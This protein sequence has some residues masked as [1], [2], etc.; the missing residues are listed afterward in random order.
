MS[1]IFYCRF[2]D[3][4]WWICSVVFHR[5]WLSLS[6]MY[7]FNITETAFMCP[8]QSKTLVFLDIEQWQTVDANNS[9][10][11]AV[12]RYQLNTGD[13]AARSVMFRQTKCRLSLVVTFCGTVPAHPYVW[14]SS[15]PW[16]HT[17][18]I[19]I[20]AQMSQY[21]K[22]PSWRPTILIHLNSLTSWYCSLPHQRGIELY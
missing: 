16:L 4:Y 1:L 2:V 12:L 8:L 13:E 7:Y 22:F 6:K 11:A 5:I 10:L 19:V 18:I 9:K 21:D 17:C 3:L 15:I 20:W 14:P